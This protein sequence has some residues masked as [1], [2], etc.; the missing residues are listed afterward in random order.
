MG[1]P[2]NVEDIQADLEIEE[3]DEEAPMQLPVIPGASYL[4]NHRER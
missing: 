1:E 3:V 2:I 4:D